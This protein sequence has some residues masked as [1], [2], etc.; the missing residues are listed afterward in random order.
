[1]AML[2]FY[3][4]INEGGR[5]SVRSGIKTFNYGKLDSY[6]TY[7]NSVKARIMQLYNDDFTKPNPTGTDKIF[8]GVAGKT[9]MNILDNPNNKELKKELKNIYDDAKKAHLEYQNKKKK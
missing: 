9:I 2:S 7:D 8:M 1:M 6:N 3:E 5:Y 4:F